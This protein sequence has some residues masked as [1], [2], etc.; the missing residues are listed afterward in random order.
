MKPERLFVEASGMSDPSGLDRILSDYRLAADFVLIRIICL[1]DAVRTPAMMDNLPALI[2]QLEAADL[3]LVNKSD[4]VDEGEIA[5]FEA[6][7]A[8][9]NPGARMLRTVYARFNLE[10]LEGGESAHRRGD[11]VSC[12]QPSNR[13]GT[14]QLDTDGLPKDRVDA[15]L[16]DH[17]KLTWRIK[18][19]TKVEGRWWFVSD[20]AGSIQWDES[21]LP[22]GMVPG[23]TIITPPGG[24]Q[25]VADAFRRMT[26]D[27]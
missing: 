15:F 12:N 1:A 5:A 27:R 13:P 21:D 7:L 26:G 19:W 11:I 24:E 4:L 17:L 6:R 3:I 20:N 2:R 16:H 25:A 9:L 10:E 14:M 8:K 22:D 23:L 18:G